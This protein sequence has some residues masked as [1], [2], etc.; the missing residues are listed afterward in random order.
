[1]LGF[2]VSSLAARYMHQF[3]VSPVLPRGLSIEI[4]A[5]PVIKEGG[6]E[7][8]MADSTQIVY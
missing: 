8:T 7:Y 6:A 2:F 5:M 4:S 3:N 1:M